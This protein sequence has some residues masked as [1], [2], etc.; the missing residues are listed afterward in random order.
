MLVICRRVAR[1]L[2]G[3]RDR[4]WAAL[5]M[6]ALAVALALTFTRSAWVGVCVGGRR[7]CSC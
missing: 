5:V 2:F 4:I 3:S 6:P 1:L 7:C